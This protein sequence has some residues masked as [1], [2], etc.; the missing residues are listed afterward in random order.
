MSF[1]RDLET[2]SG[3]KSYAIKKLIP[4]LYKK[5]SHGTFAQGVIDLAMEAKYL[6][7]LQHPHIINIRAIADIDDSSK[8]FFIVI[9]RLVMTL[10]HQINNWKNRLIGWQSFRGQRKNNKKELFCEQLMVA[11]DICSALAYL[12]SKK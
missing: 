1:Y 3:K 8:D 7:V 11:H 5:Q 12:H 10:E 4:G 2:R 6:S 9:D